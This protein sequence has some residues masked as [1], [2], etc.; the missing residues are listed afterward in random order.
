MKRIV[1]FAIIFVVIGEIFIRLD[2]LI[3]PL[4]GN[5]IVKITTKLEETREYNLVKT[6]NVDF[7]KDVLRIMV[8]GDS[9]IHGGGIKFKDNVSQKLKSMLIKE[10]SFQYKEVLVLDV[11]RSS[12]NSLDN[13]LTYFS[14]IDQFKPQIVILGYNINDT[15]GNL[16]K[17]MD[18]MPSDS[19]E[20]DRQFS[21][22]KIYKIAYKSEF[23]RFWLHGAH[24][25][26][27]ANGFVIP[28]TSFDLN[29]K[30]YYQDRAA[31]RQSKVL[32]KEMIEHSCANNIKLIVYKFPE[33]NLINHMHLFDEAD[34]A[35][36]TFFSGFPSLVFID[37]NKDFANEPSS[38]YV[39][40]KY[41]GHPNEKAHE[42]V[43]MVLFEK[44]DVITD[45]NSS[46]VCH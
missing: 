40:S 27:K 35:I 30:N 37:G 32:L 3:K 31:W 9:Y 25:K 24:N 41:D 21:V 46:Y 36:E 33:M 13:N 16:N 6:H 44:L 23:I 2:M 19:K 34:Q 42:K 20:K 45:N 8:L 29:L 39:L 11:S 14:F 17:L 18:E 5:K 15:E 22:S 7:S 43:A 10:K 26:L 12:S 4:E 28:Q 1:T 38:E